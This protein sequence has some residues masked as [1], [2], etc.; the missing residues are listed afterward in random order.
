MMEDHASSGTD[1]A[2]RQPGEDHTLHIRWSEPKGFVW[3]SIRNFLLTILTLG[4]YSFWGKTEVRRRIWNAVRINDEP[5][6]YTGTGWE[7]FRGF[8]LAAVF[9]GGG[10]MI[11]GVIVAILSA[12]NE[13]LAQILFLPLYV[14]GFWLFGLAIYRTWRYRL[15]R[16]RWRGIRATLAGSPVKYANAYFLSGL[17][18]PLSLGWLL[19]WRLRKLHTLMTRDTRIGTARLRVDPEPALGPLYRVFAPLWFGGLLPYVLILLLVVEVINAAIRHQGGQPIAMPV[20]LPPALLVVLLVLSLLLFMWLRYRYL[21]QATNW[22]TGHVRL[23]GGRFRLNLR[24][25]RLFLLHLGNLFIILLSLG[26]LAPVAQKRLAR[27][28]VSNISFE[29]AVDL[30]SLRQ[31]TDTLEK[32]GEGMGE[33]FDIDGF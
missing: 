22:L 20:E 16:T 4:I 15:R 1:M 11:H 27:Y 13:Q 8:L 5:L 9:L 14:I 29:G 2:A 30:A 10:A 28:M 12:G 17:L 25:M 18:V 21:A 32:S 31:A 19:P 24:P 3:L 7:L 26:I 23:Q 33:F 6:E